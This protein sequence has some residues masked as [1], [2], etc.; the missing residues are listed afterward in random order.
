ME[1]ELACM[2]DLETVST[3][4]TAAIIEIGA[5]AFRLSVAGV[6]ST[7]FLAQ[8]SQKHY[9]KDV[10]DNPFD[11]DPET[12]AWWLADPKRALHYRECMLSRISLRTAL[13]DFSAWYGKCGFT[14]IWCRGASFDL[15]IL[16]HAYAAFDLKLP[17][18][19]RTERCSRTMLAHWDPSN[20][21]RPENNNW[22]SALSDAYA[23]IEHL[24]A[25]Q[26]HKMAAPKLPSSLFETR[27]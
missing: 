26:Q 6:G 18:A 14:S 5:H 7:A 9:K 17:W 1:E 2:I 11:I 25:C 23:E 21:L 3:L 10:T 20:E 15:A 4:P 24:Q 16:R 8:I 19:F 13:Q 22:H 27:L 12:V